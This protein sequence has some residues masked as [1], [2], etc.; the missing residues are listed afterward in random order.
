MLI[1]LELVNGEADAEAGP[2][3]FHMCAEVAAMFADD[4]HGVVQRQAEALAGCLGGEEGFKDAVLDFGGD[5]GTVVADL[6]E[7]HFAFAAADEFQLGRAGTG[8]DGIEGVEG[9]FEDGSP[10]LVE[11]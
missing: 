4:A 1:G 11:L 7:E 2:A 9:I 5:A 8:W 10:D 6:D 3:V